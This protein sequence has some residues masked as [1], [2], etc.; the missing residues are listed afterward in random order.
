MYGL[1]V[2][3]IPRKVAR[4]NGPEEHAGLAAFRPVIGLVVLLGAYCAVLFFSLIQTSDAFPGI[5]AFR[6]SG[7]FAAALGSACFALL[8]IFFAIARFSFGYFV[9]FYFY[10]MIFGY[11]SLVGFS[12]LSYDHRLAV[13]SIVL[14][15]I[16]FL[17]PALFLTSPIKRPF[18]WPKQRFDVLPSVILLLAAAILAAGAFYNFKPASFSEMYKFRAQ[19]QLPAWLRYATGITIGSLLPFAFACFVERRKYLQAALALLA[20]VLM[21]PIALTKLS[22]FAAPWLLFLAVLSRMLAPRPAVI[23]SLLLPLSAGMALPFLMQAGAVPTQLGLMFVG[24]VNSRMIALPAISLEAYNEFFARSAL[25]HFCQINLVKLVM[26][27]P[28]DEPLSIVMSKAYNLGNLNASLFATEGTAS[29]GAFWAPLSA[30]ACGLII[31]FANRLSAGLPAKFVIV[32][33]GMLPHLLLNVPLST[34]L[35][36]NGAAVLFLLWY[37]TPR[38]AFAADKPPAQKEPAQDR[39]SLPAS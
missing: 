27:C 31:G 17:A 36:S 24:T 13:V 1:D 6:P 32:S 9:G 18:E 15:C 11:V 39:K 28:Y 26:A 19:I 25:T 30:L 7:V 22:L 8:A 21:Y 35:L 14:S 12:E 2:E 3:T 34:T 29:V 33:A 4:V 10:T 38:S 37:I 5:I 20:L 16:A 23:L